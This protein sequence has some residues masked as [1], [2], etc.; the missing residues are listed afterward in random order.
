MDIGE[1][2]GRLLMKR[3]RC[4]LTILHFSKTGLDFFDGTQVV[5]DGRNTVGV[6]FEAGKFA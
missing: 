4:Q 6:E 1:V 5:Y 3:Y 2:P